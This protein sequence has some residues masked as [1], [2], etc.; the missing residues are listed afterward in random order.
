M[1]I[2]G[3]CWAIRIQKNATATQRAKKKPPRHLYPHSALPH[4]A[5]CNSLFCIWAFIQVVVVVGYPCG[6]T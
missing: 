5:D 2:L 6:I 4:F 1:H 3:N